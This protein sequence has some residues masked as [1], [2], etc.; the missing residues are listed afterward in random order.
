MLSLVALVIIY[1]NNKYRRSI[2][3]QTKKE[4]SAI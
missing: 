2:S 1:N 3:K 4:N